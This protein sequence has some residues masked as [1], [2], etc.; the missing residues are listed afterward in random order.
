M[1]EGPQ[2]KGYWA[3]VFK[4]SSLHQAFNEADDSIIENISSISTNVT[5]DH[6]E[7]EIEFS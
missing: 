3:K 4:K 2:M 1:E 5:T 7:I 6:L